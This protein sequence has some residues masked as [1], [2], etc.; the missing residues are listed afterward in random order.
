[1][2]RTPAQ[3]PDPGSESPVEM[4]DAC[5]DKIRQFTRLCLRLA[6]HLEEHGPDDQAV[7]AAS[8]I[9][10][11]FRLAAPLHHQDEEL[12]LFPAL[13]GLERPLID[14]HQARTLRAQIGILESEHRQLEEIWRDI[15]PWLES[16]EK[17][18]ESASPRG[19]KK[20]VDI[21]DAHIEREH[22]KVF[23]CVAFLPDW[24]RRQI[25]LRMA[26]RRGLTV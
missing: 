19:L 9:L 25:C 23:P 4:L 26:Q 15:E 7:Q 8:R 5:H 22:S 3:E 10:R 13:L 20:F 11:Y 17:G 14:A 21:Y 6:A 18:Q 24:Q 2:S 16:I 12:D 1:M